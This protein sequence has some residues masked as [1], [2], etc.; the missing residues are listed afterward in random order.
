M[1]FE[2]VYGK[3]LCQELNLLVNEKDDKITCRKY[4]AVS[5][6]PL[7]KNANQVAVVVDGGGALRSEYKGRDLNTMT[8]NVVL[9]CRLENA[10]IVAEAVET[11]QQDY[12]AT[13]MEFSN[14][15]TYARAIFTTPITVDAGD[16]QTE[17]EGSVK[18]VFKTFTASIVYGAT[19]QVIPPVYA[20]AEPE[21]F[22]LQIGGGEL[23]P[24]TNLLSYNAHSSPSCDTYLPQG[25]V[26]T[27]HTQLAKALGYSFTIVK[28]KESD[29]LQTIFENELYQDPMEN[30]GGLYL[31]GTTLKL[32]IGEEGEGKVFT[33]G[34]YDLTKQYAEGQI[35]YVL[36][37]SR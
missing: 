8:L 18:V 7:K 15:T 14:P 2:E 34:T 36:S 5:F 13:V 25:Q 12:N 22:Y 37:L 3:W 29:E 20:L 1:I 21:P 9:I 26:Q 11:F 16:L 32:Y 19:A 31:F 33:A 6:K 10:G 35:V 24:I 17:Q 23:I 28:V 27:K 30:P 4:G